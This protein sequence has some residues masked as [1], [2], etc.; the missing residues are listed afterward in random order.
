MKALAAL[1]VASFF[2]RVFMR[3]TSNRH[4]GFYWDGS[5]MRISAI[6]DFEE[7]DYHL[8]LELREMLP[9]TEKREGASRQ[10]A[11]IA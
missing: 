1:S 9:T 6:D 10:P 7:R 5:D 11:S 2:V 4:V 8:A 3:A